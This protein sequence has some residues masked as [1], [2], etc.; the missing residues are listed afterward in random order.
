[1]LIAA[2]FISLLKL[3]STANLCTLHFSPA[4]VRDSTGSFPLAERKPDP[5]K[6]EDN[7]TQSYLK[8]SQACPPLP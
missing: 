5:R 7:G 2:V 3:P 4:L 8:F 1:M 6:K